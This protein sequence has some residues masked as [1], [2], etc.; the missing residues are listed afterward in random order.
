M[1]QLIYIPRRLESV[2][3]KVCVH[4]I[5]VVP[6]HPENITRL[7]TM[8]Y[9]NRFYSLLMGAMMLLTAGNMRAQSW[10][11]QLRRQEIVDSIVRLADQTPLPASPYC[12]YM[13]YYHQ[14][15]QHE[16]PSGEQFRLRAL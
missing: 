8:Y 7:N 16:N 11:D 10:L 13:I 1:A 5:F 3:K 6:L 4:Q 2:I 14:P 12:S 15:L 9:Q